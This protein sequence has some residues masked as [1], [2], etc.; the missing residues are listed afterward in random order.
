[1]NFVSPATGYWFLFGFAIVITFVTYYFSRWKGWQTKEGFLLANRKVGWLLGGFSIAASWI[2]APAL[3]VSVQLAYQKGLAGLF[4]FTVPNILSLTIFAL[5]APRIRSRMPAG[6]TL[7]EY[8]K[9]RFRTRRV[10]RM[11]LF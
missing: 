5:L 2:W 6:Y 7:P 4:W 10:H 9:E 11:Y 8:V 3:F 1:M